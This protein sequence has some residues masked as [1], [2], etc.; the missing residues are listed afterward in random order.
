MCS[1]GAQNSERCSARQ[2]LNAPVTVDSMGQAKIGGAL[3]RRA[4]DRSRA[5]LEKASAKIGEMRAANNLQ[6]IAD[7]WSEH[8]TN[9]QRAFTKLRMAC[10]E[11]ASKG[12]CDNVFHE[13]SKD[14]LLSYVLHARNADEHGVASITAH[15]AGTIG[16]GPKTG[17]SL[18]I[19]HLSIGPG[20]ITMGPNLAANARIS[21]TPGEVLL[22]PVRDRGI[23]YDVPKEH[24]GEKL[25]APTLLS[26]AERAEAFLRAKLDEAGAKF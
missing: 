20:G 9:L 25:D 22:V 12:W 14:P 7:L 5:E 4:F 26:V 19:D 10:K 15:K 21:F 6:E 8:L 24:L 23:V 11:G 18:E 1:D 17:N 13:R 3:D 2:L 16:I